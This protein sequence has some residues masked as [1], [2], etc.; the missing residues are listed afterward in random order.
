MVL[1]I[2]HFDSYFF[3]LETLYRALTPP[4]YHKDW[5][6]GVRIAENKKLVGLI[7][8]IPVQCR[9]YSKYVHLCCPFYNQL[10]LIKS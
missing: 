4:G 7:T 10:S 1:Y 8:G 5:H 2:V 6:I 3:K 9:V